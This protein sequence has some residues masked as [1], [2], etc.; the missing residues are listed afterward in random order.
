MRPKILINALHTVTGG[1]LTY[2]N[3]ILPELARDERFEWVLLLCPE[4][5]GKVKVPLKVE[6]KVTP[7]LNFASG[8]LYE[9]LVLPVLC[10]RWG[11]GAVLCNAN[12][13][14][15]LAP[16]P[17]PIV[18]TTARAAEQAQSL[19]MKF[20]WQVLVLLT[21]ISLL[22]APLAFSVCKGVIADYANGRTA[23][24]IRLA[25]SAVVPPP[26]AADHTREPNMVVTIGDFYPQKD[27]PTLLRA[28][29]L[30]RERRPASRLV[31]IGKPVDVRV[32]DEVLGLIRE[33]GLAEAVTLTGAIP[34]DALLNTLRRASVYVSTSKAETFNIPV[35]EAMACG[36]PCVL[37]DADFQ[38]EVAGDAAVFVPG[39]KGGDVPAAFA[40]ALYGLLEN[41]HIAAALRRA[42]A[43]HVA[44]FSWDRTAHV[45]GEGLAEALRK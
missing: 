18:H 37:G 23:R 39:D 40:V 33:L 27:Y 43:A 38:R 20:Y 9:Q 19:G 36:V 29:Q 12:Y 44:A 22:R 5:V 34:H 26:P 25:Y 7:A 32:R 2:L 28:F 15:L 13:V 3:G 4:A 10:R 14:P 1:G 6:V 45:I 8:H 31:I 11:I 41:T 42:G 35:L 24:K 21:R 30:L 16:R 17:I